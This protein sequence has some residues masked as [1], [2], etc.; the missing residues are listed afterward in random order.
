M[1]VA[2]ARRREP[3]TRAYSQ[4]SKGK[5]SNAQLINT[6]TDLGKAW[7]LCPCGSTRGGRRD[8]YRVQFARTRRTLSLFP[9]KSC[10]HLRRLCP[11]LVSG[12]LLRFS[13]NST[14]T[15]PCQCEK[16]RYSIR[17]CLCLSIFSPSTTQDSRTATR[18]PFQA[19][20]HTLIT[21]LNSRVNAA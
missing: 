20:T 7:P 16:T 6:T 14:T 19:I 8:N 12:S 9:T 1:T 4:R 18:A 3:L 17:T 13:F 2:S 15:W 21:T 11:L 5:F 10:P